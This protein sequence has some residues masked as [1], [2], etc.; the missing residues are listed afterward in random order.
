MDLTSRAD[1]KE[2]IR[3]TEDSNPRTEQDK[4]T[5]IMTKYRMS[6]VCKQ[7]CIPILQLKFNS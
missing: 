7:Y 5:M 6:D 4:S 3:T 2:E 1:S